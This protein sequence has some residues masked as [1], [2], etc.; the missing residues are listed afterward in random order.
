MG[1]QIFFILVSLLTIVMKSH[2]LTIQENNEVLIEDS[3]KQRKK[4]DFYEKTL[5]SVEEELKN[6]LKISVFLST[7]IIKRKKKK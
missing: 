2:E 5:I 1:I 4:E 3:P 6:M 7:Q